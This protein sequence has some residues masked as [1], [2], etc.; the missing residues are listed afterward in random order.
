MTDNSQ[1]GY[2]YPQ[3]SLFIDGGW[4]KGSGGRTIPVLNPAT[5]EEIG[6]VAHA[7]TSDLEHAVQAA[8][9]AFKTWRKVPAFDR[10]KIMRRAAELLRSRADDIAKIMTAEQGKPLLEAKMEAMAGA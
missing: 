10:Y 4:T 6:A 3:V 2:M 9:K 7:E 5:A 8:D 1:G